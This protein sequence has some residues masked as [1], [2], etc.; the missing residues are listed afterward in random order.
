M[1]QGRQSEA[2]GR[3]AFTLPTR[4]FTLIE[5]LVVIAIIAILAAFLFPVF[6]KVRE[7]AR[8]TSCE[9]NLKQLGLAITQ[10]SQDSDEQMP[11]LGS[12][13]NGTTVTWRGA[14]YPYVKSKGVYLC[15]SNSLNTLPTTDDPLV[16]T[17]S[18]GANETV[19][20][21]LPQPAL[22][23]PGQA[24]TLNDIQAPA[25]MFVVGESDSPLARLHNPPNSPS[26]MPDCANCDF[27][28]AIGVRTDLFAGHTG[29]SNWLFADGHVKALRPTQTCLDTDA[30]DLD[31]SNANQPCSAALQFALLENEHY[32]DQTS[33]P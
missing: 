3:A 32:W 28:A 8:R 20:S 10:Y 16:F 13:P 4:G 24:V 12:A 25:Q 17:V 18:Y 15:P 9:S 7:N 5:L 6:Q 22:G 30:W 33:T 23:L 14:I 21:A 11:L 31:N 29:R 19:F 2:G 27:Q 26:S 1:T